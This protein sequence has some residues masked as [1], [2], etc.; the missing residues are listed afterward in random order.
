MKTLKSSPS[1]RFAQMKSVFLVVMAFIRWHE[2][3][4]A[5]IDQIATRPGRIGADMSRLTAILED[6][7]H[8]K[9]NVPEAQKRIVYLWLDSNIPFYGTYTKDEQ[10]AQKRGL[11]IPEP[12]AQ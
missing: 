1:S 4:G 10:A 5:S 3:G 2:W 9:L 6:A 8:A 11:A 7:T 12:K